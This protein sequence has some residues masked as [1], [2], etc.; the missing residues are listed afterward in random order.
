MDVLDNDFDVVLEGGLVLFYP[1]SQSAGEWAA[2]ELRDATRWGDAYVVEYRY[3]APIV[4]DL[5]S[6]A[7]TLT[8]VGYAHNVALAGERP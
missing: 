6:H 3:A 7:Y 5:V 2:D 1:V 8:L 4:Q